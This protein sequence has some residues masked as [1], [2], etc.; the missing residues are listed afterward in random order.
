MSFNDALKRLE[1]ERRAEKAR[2]MAKLDLFAK[3]RK[4]WD[5]PED[6]PIRY[7]ALKLKENPISSLYKQELP[8]SENPAAPRHFPDATGWIATLRN[9]LTEFRE[10][11]A[12]DFRRDVEREELRHPTGWTAA[13][14]EPD[15]F[16][17]KLKGCRYGKF[18][19]KIPEEKQYLTD[20]IRTKPSEEDKFYPRILT[21]AE[22][23]ISIRNLRRLQPF[24][25]STTQDAKVADIALGIVQNPV[26]VD[27]EARTVAKFVPYATNPV[28]TL[29]KRRYDNEVVPAIAD[30]MSSYTLGSGLAIFRLKEPRAKPLDSMVAVT[31]QI[32]R[33][34]YCPA[35]IRGIIEKGKVRDTYVDAVVA[36]AEEL[37]R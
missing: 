12:D 21:P 31:E 10:L 25:C 14:R 26:F 29:V 1:E 27:L 17:E 23:D 8:C 16:L 2:A 6:K 30:A 5:F 34:N 15:K 11:H 19:E 35:Q 4:P 22:L 20:F 32:N 37:V 7:N 18:L 3:P 24:A 13:L 33:V 28:T 36:R 9:P